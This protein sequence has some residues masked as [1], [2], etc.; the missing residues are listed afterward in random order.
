M[1]QI[2]CSLVVAFVLAASAMF[3]ASSI[4]RSL[5]VRPAPPDIGEC[6]PYT[7]SL[8]INPMLPGYLWHG[9]EAGTL[10][11]RSEIVP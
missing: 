4:A 9:S 3:T 2:A 5:V 1:K 10:R 6:V 8:F 11:A 7:N